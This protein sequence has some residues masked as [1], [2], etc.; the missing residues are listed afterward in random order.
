MTNPDGTPSLEHRC[1]SCFQL[2]STWEYEGLHVC[3]NCWR[4]RRG[5]R[6][7]L[8]AATHRPQRRRKGQ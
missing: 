7:A 3:R 6:A 2:R 1:A 5:I 8:S 4:K